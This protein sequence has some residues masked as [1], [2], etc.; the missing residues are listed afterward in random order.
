MPD[1][2]TIVKFTTRNTI[3]KLIY[4]T[5]I[6]MDRPPEIIV[7][8]KIPVKVSVRTTS[9]G[10]VQPDSPT[11]IVTIPFILLPASF[12]KIGPRPTVSPA[13]IVRPASPAKIVRPASPAKIVRPASPA[14]IVRPASPAK[15]S[16]R[17]IAQ[18]S[19]QRKSVYW[20]KPVDVVESG[21]ISS[22]SLKKIENKWIG[23]DQISCGN[24]RKLSFDIFE[25]VEEQ[26]FLTCSH[27][28]Q[29]ITNSM[30]RVAATRI[31]ADPSQSI[32][33]LLAN[34]I[35][36]YRKDSSIGKFGM[37]FFSIF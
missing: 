15:I 19:L 10:T 17:P 32:M 8:Q 18:R 16:L 25:S 1:L 30:I 9:S 35:D 29:K 11:R 13:K 37:G 3:N 33:E 21:G 27:Y 2:T 34:S 31:F 36:S 14:K 23:L 20:E 7:R 6:N 26:G 12:A 5:Q 24:I 4:F 22:I 28:G